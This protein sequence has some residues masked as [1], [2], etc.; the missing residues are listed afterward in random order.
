MNQQLYQLLSLLAFTYLEHG[1]AAKA[2][3]LLEALHEVDAN[4]PRQS[5]LLAL[6]HLKAGDAE[7][8]LNQ[9]E[10][11]VRRFGPTGS[12]HRT[13]RWI[14]ARA[15]WAV[16]RHGEARELIDQYQTVVS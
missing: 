3:T 6:S 8:S 4:Q 14:K 2:V 13:F 11:H 10:R 15:L 7:S 1:K 12:D 5:M 16:G 9:L